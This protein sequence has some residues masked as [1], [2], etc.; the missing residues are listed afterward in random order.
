MRKLLPLAAIIMFAAVI[1][2]ARDGHAQR[3]ASDSREINE[4]AQSDGP[5]PPSRQRN[6][7]ERPRTLIACTRTGCR[8]IPPGCW[9]EIERDWDGLPTGFDAVICPFR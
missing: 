4:A 6:L 9:I 2:A 8:S 3:P 1:L 7:Y 5:R